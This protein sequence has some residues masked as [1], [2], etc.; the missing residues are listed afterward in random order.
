MEGIPLIMSEST[1]DTLTWTIGF[2]DLALDFMNSLLPIFRKS[3]PIW[4]RTTL[5]TGPPVR[6]INSNGLG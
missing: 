3:S 4:R 2:M 6:H 5:V 1:S